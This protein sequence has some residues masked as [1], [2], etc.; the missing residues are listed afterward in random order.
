[1][2]AVLAVAQCGLGPHGRGDLEREDA[3]A[4]GDRHEAQVEGP[5]AAVGVGELGGEATAGAP[6]HAALELGEQRGLL[7]AWMTLEHAAAEQALAGGVALGG[8]GRVEVHVGEVGG[9]DRAALEEVVEHAAREPVEV[10]RLGCAHPG[11]VSRLA[12]DVI[13]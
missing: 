6:D 12:G 1:M 8:G 5:A 13:K 3:H 11:R 7:D 2:E 4:L 9:D 10:A